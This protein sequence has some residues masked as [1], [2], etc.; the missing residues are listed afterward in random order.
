MTF[1][2]ALSFSVL[3]LTALVVVTGLA[4]CG[5]DAEP[6]FRGKVVEDAEPPTPPLAGVN[7]DG[8][9]F[10]LASQEG[11]VSVVF[12]GYT[13]CPDVCP[14]ALAKMKQL[15]AQLGDR[16]DEV[17]VVFVSVDPQRDTVAKL[18]DYVP[19]FDERFYGLRLETDELEQVQE[20]W[21]V[22]VQYGQPKH[23]P[24]TD[25]F[26]YVDHTGSYFLLDRQGRLRVVHPPNASVKDLLPDV[27]KLL[28]S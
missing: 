6:Q 14:F 4:G 8:E 16:A 15:Y 1:H 2:R 28:R 10:E 18:A 13:F 7:W 20:D 19:N 22:T 25:S 11:K 12:F 23:G 24:G 5:S 9:P 3:L 26:Y 21:D 17:A 27:E